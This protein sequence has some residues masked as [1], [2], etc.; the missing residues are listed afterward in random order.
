[1]QWFD[2][3]IKYIPEVAAPAN[4]KMLAFST[5]V[6]WTLGILIL[7]FIMK[8][9]PLWGLGNNAL[10]Q[11]QQYATILAVDFGSLVS[12]GIGPIVT[13]SIVMQLLNGAGIL[14]FKT[15]TPDGKRRFLGAQKIATYFFLI[16]ESAIFV[17][18][19][20]LSPDPALAGTSTY[21]YLAMILFIQLIVG[22]LLIILMDE[23]ISRW[24]F[25]SGVSL[26]IVGGV[27]EQIIVRAISWIKPAGSE[28][29]VGAI[30]QIF[31][32][33]ALNDPQTALLAIGAILATIVV[34]CF[35]VYG[36]AMK[37]E[38]PLSFGRIRGQG[39]RWPLNFI[40][41]SNI[42]V[43]LVAALLANISLGATLLSSRF[44]WNPQTVIGW[45]SPL[46]LVPELIKTGSLFAIPGVL[47]VQTLVYGVILIGGAIIFSWFWVQSAG[48]DAHS[49]AKQI[50]ASGLQIPG[51]R[52]DPRVMEHL[53]ERY[54]GPLT[55]MGGALI[56]IL[57]FSADVL[58]ALVDGTSLLLSV[59]IIYR[60]YEEIAKQHMMDV[61][62]MMRKMMGGI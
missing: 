52:K 38:I 59:M 33:L 27:S 50:M 49:Q 5:K 62:P 23:V 22:G 56:G 60:L 2:N 41:T 54:I 3:L 12:L 44:G 11:F 34:F 15:N 39:I 8:T 29:S 40:Y 37:I 47:Y 43:I 30:P 57:A 25:G 18:T 24:G 32:S 6:K 9:V 7:F 61:N 53:L 58:G 13:A 20:A 45:V 19:G 35:A 51:F 17:M 55:I 46:P 4:K 1:M 26:F 36:Q 28:Y 48:M 14:K 42:P 31:Q 10:A 21:T 16:F